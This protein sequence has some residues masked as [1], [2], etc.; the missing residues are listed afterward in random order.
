MVTLPHSVIDRLAAMRRPGESDV[1]LEAGEGL[2][3]GEGG[4]VLGLARSPT[5]KSKAAT[6]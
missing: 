6:A 2:R 4:R 1:I 5:M 3:E